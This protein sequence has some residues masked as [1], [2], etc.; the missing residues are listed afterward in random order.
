MNKEMFVLTMG[1]LYVPFVPCS[2]LY[3]GVDF[4]QLV[5]RHSLQFVS[6][7]ETGLQDQHSA[8]STSENSNGK[9]CQH[10]RC[11]CKRALHSILDL[12]KTVVISWSK[13]YIQFSQ[14][15]SLCSS[16]YFV[17]P[18]SKVLQ[19]KPKCRSKTLNLA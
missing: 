19:S 5:I 12:S 1:L 13:W 14:N 3:C 2:P 9:I 4:V 11:I 8:T 17:C 15:L 10:S 7:V 18:K 16:L 6:F